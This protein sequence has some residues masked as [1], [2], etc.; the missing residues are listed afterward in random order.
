MHS[1]QAGLFA[2]PR[3]T[4]IETKSA[5]GFAFVVLPRFGQQMF[6]SS[7][8]RKRRVEPPVDV[9]PQFIGVANVVAV[10]HRSVDES[11][12]LIDLFPGT[13]TLLTG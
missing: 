1:G 9:L 6:A 11:R 2:D 3:I 5:G 8:G 4:S 7:V 13:Q 10:D 12:V